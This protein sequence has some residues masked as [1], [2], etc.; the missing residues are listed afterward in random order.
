MQIPTVTLR[1]TDDDVSLI[2]FAL[3]KA[4]ELSV[5]NADECASG[6]AKPNSAMEQIFRAQNDRIVSLIHS[7]T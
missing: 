2:L 5:R 6:L 4:A 3:E 7:L 1:L